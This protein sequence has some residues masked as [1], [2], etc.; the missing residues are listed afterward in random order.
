METAESGVEDMQ[1]SANEAEENSE[2]G[3][4]EYEEA[5]EDIRMCPSCGHKGP[6]Y[7]HCTYCD[8]LEPRY[9]VAIGADN[10]GMNQTDEEHE[11]TIASAKAFS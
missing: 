11:V 6:L 10:Y 1:M 5:F 9:S 4:G 2:E 7:V 8:D 3:S